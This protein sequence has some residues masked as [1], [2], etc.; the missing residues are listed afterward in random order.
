MELVI[1]NEHNPYDK[2]NLHAGLLS[3]DV[4]RTVI[5]NVKRKHCSC[6]NSVDKHDHNV[7]TGN[8]SSSSSSSS[9]GVKLS[10][11][12]LKRLESLWKTDLRS[13]NVFP[14]VFNHSS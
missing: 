5:D 14:Y 12:Q 13:I 8:L 1:K 9:S 2:L 7:P 4:I 6:S 10:D 11:D 3:F